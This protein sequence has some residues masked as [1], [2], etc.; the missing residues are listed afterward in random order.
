MDKA[1]LQDR[2]KAELEAQGFEVDVFDNSA[3]QIYPLFFVLLDVLLHHYQNKS[4][5]K[6]VPLAHLLDGMDYEQIHIY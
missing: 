3:V 1:T 5:Y 6:L 4:L 2:V